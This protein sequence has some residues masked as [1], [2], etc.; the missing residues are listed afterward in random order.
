MN[1]FE[2]LK[3]MTVEE[4]AMWLDENG[5]FDDSPWNDWFN[6]KFCEKCESI[7]LEYEDSKTIL[8]IEPLS[9]DLTSECAYCECHDHC[10]FFPEIKDIPDNRKV[11]EMW[12]TEEAEND[13]ET[14]TKLRSPAHY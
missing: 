9:L 10:R 5:M 2:H 3:A 6:K 14:A 8:G 1:N 4:L 13:G 7:E 11:I 12:L